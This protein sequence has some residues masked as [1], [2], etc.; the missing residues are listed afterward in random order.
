MQYPPVGK[1]EAI[2][3]E[4]YKE[5]RPKWEQKKDMSIGY[6]LEKFIKDDSPS[7]VTYEK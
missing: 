7:P 5:R 3:L 2:K 6:R 4:I 1:Y